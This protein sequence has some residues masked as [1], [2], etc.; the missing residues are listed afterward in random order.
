M[1]DYEEEDVVSIPKKINTIIYSTEITN[2][3]VFRQIFVQILNIPV[4]FTEEKDVF[5]NSS[6]PKIIERLLTQSL[7][8]NIL[9]SAFS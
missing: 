5:L 7:L 4:S 1:S 3:Y 9:T 8:P 6:F 2:G